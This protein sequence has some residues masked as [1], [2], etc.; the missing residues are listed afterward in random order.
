MAT[1]KRK[2]TA[3]Q[4]RAQVTSSRN[5][6]LYS[7]VWFAVALFLMAIVFVVVAAAMDFAIYYP[8]FKVYD[9]QKCKEDSGNALIL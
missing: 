8:F 6:Q 9:K 4:K 2:S 1:K 7:V 5:R 3:A